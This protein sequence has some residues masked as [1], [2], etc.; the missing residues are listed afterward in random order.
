GQTH[1]RPPT[2]ETSVFGGRV[3]RA[4]CG[5]Q[6]C[7]RGGAL[8]LVGNRSWAAGQHLDDASGHCSLGLDLEKNRWVPPSA[9]KQTERPGAICP[10]TCRLTPCSLSM[11]AAPILA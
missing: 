7:H 10:P 1:S 6:R 3:A 2:Q 8:P 9:A 4:T 5:A 11:N